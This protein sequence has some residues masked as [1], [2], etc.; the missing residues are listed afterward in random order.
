M[1]LVHIFWR[2]FIWALP[3]LILVWFIYTAKVR[4]EDY[5]LPEELVIGI[6]GFMLAASWINIPLVARISINLGGGLIPIGAAFFLLL[7]APLK[8]TGIATAVM[9]GVGLFF[10]RVVSKGV[11]ISVLAPP[12]IAAAVAWFLAGEQ[13]A[14]VAF[15]SGVF[16]V[17]IG[18]DL[19]RVPWLFLRGA[20]ALSIGGAGV[21]DAIFLIGIAA[22]LLAGF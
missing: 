5:G 14:P 8:E 4:F 10:G 1:F 7:Q 21:F 19:I 9:I 11:S 20:G 2:G 6:F 12:L 3:L 15:I 18:A 22:A 17:L 16:G 13:A